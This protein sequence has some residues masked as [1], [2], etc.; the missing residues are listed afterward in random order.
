[1]A[2][3][4]SDVLKELIK[5]AKD[6]KVV[7]QAK[8][9][10]AEMSQRKAEITAQ[11]GGSLGAAE[12]LKEGAS[13]VKDDKVAVDIKDLLKETKDQ[14]VSLK[15]LVKLNQKSIEDNSELFGRLE[16]TM[17]SLLDSLQEQNRDK[18]NTQTNTTGFSRSI[19]GAPSGGNAPNGG[20]GFQIPDLGGFKR[21]IG[22]GAAGGG[23]KRSIGTGAAGNAGRSLGSR[24]LGGLTSAPALGAM[25]YGALGY[26]VLNGIEETGKTPEGAKQTTQNIMGGLDPSGMNT[27]IGDSGLT[28][29]ETERLNKKQQK[30]KEQLK[31]APWYTRLY[32]IGASEHIKNKETIEQ[33]DKALEEK[34]GRD[35]RANVTGE[36]GP[37][38]LFTEQN[39]NGF[40]SRSEKEKEKVLSQPILPV[41]VTPDITGIMPEA[42]GR[43]EFDPA[44]VNKEAQIPGVTPDITGIMM[45]AKETGRGL[46]SDIGDK[47]KG[48]AN[49]VQ[50]AYHRGNRGT[51]E[52]QNLGKKSLEEWRQMGGEDSDTEGF[53]DY[54]DQ[55]QKEAYKTGATTS[56]TE[57]LSASRNYEKNVTQEG[58][59]TSSTDSMRSGVALEKSLFGS[60]ALGSLVAEKGLET[61]SFLGTGSDY[62]T[63]Q[64]ESGK[65]ASKSKMTE[66]LGKRTSGG[67]L[68]A[69]KHEISEIS[70]RDVITTDVTK[71]VYHDIQEL[72]KDGKID[73]ASKKLQEFKRFMQESNANVGVT[74]MGDTGSMGGAIGKAEATVAPVTEEKKFDIG[75]ITS[76]QLEGENQDYTKDITPDDT[77]TDAVISRLA[78]MFNAK[79]AEKAA[80]DES[81]KA[82]IIV[83]NQGGD[84]ITNIT[85]NTAGGSS[86]GAGSPSRMPGPWDVMTLGK[87]W[88]AYP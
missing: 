69:D 66:L 13:S 43:K 25:A 42:T 64:D 23:F 35:E 7:E 11:I 78:E 83:T 4:Q 3:D 38:G 16:K 10:L 63:T 61:G 15:S 26:G 79:T 77:Q 44:L 6:P 72:V 70:G 45:P 33:R 40:Q 46:F 27:K 60:T 84:T 5:Q 82:P 29:D 39:A 34:I 65:E 9:A 21:S 57:M 87:S 48:V 2:K 58:G 47:I 56:G 51:L 8:A 50:D 12:K 14:S 80:S 68:G 49:E 20:G 59:K 22:T 1:M 71:A 31:D 37:R 36:E 54:Y 75:S 18:S 74:A 55:K 73:E 81:S 85:N 53:M 41:G 67:L 30:E 17:S 52:G 19:G 24:L 32:G 88:E 62:Q 76:K 28:P 86:G